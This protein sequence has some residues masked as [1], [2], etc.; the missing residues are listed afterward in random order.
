MA[1]SPPALRRN[2]LFLLVICLGACARTADPGP[3]APAAPATAA[4]ARAEP[5]DE[6]CADCHPDEVEA[7]RA[8]G[9][10]RSMAPVADAPVI[11]AG[12]PVEVAH[13]VSGF[14]YTVYRDEA[15]RLWQEERLIADPTRV[16]R[17]EARYVIGSGNHGRSYAGL[18]DGTLVELP[19]TWYS[20]RNLWDLSPGYDRRDQWRFERPVKPAC[21]FCHNGLTPQIPGTVASYRE[22]L[23]HGIRLRALPRR[24]GGPC[25]RAP[26]ACGWGDAAVPAGQADPTIFNPGREPPARQLQVCQQC[27]LQGQA[28]VLHAGQ[29]WDTYDPRE[30]LADYFSVY[31]EAGEGGQKFTV[32]SHG[33]R[34]KLS[35]CARDPRLACT[36]C[37]DPHTTPSVARSRAACLSCHSTGATCPDPAAADAAQA[38]ARCHMPAGGPADVPHVHFT[39]HFIRRR[40]EVVDR[41]AG[42]A[43]EL[44]ALLDGPRRRPSSSGCGWGW[45]GRPWGGG[46]RGAP[47]GH[48]DRAADGGDARGAGG[49][50]SCPPPGRPSGAASCARAGRPRPRPRWSAS[51][52]PRSRTR[53]GCRTSWR[54]RRPQSGTWTRRAGR[55]KPPWPA[56]RRRPAGSSSAACCAARGGWPRPDPPSTRPSA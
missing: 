9:M 6:V 24:R 17:L 47:P 37:H 49:P 31:R 39:D 22:P 36:T 21:L 26:G 48:R 45:P 20:R 14:R 46:G 7:F 50:P 29:R 28:T 1:P 5:G 52:R 16:R 25:G 38:C 23:A 10:G 4:P 13:P 56:T 15:G 2:L 54:P 30:P 53:R 43:G 3:A 12:G 11:E 51:R 41:P 55:S 8:T 35:A 34:L 40:P 27:H 33:H 18:R 42:P 32:A 19:L 44:V